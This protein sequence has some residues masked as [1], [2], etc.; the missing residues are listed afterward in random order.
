MTGKFVPSSEATREQLDWG[1]MGWL[2]RPPDTGASQLTWMWA[3]K[4]LSKN[5]VK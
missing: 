5:N 4:L 2:S 1:V 3:I